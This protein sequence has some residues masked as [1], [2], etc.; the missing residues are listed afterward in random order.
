[1]KN[2]GVSMSDG[3]CVQWKRALV[4][5]V[6]L[7]GLVAV[8]GAAHAQFTVLSQSRTLKV[9]TFGSGSE[10]DWASDRLG[11]PGRYITTEWNKSDNSAWLDVG[12]FSSVLGVD[13]S[14]SSNSGS[15]RADLTSMVSDS[16]ISASGSFSAEANA[17][18]PTSGGVR[19]TASSSSLISLKVSFSLIE[20]TDLSFVFISDNGSGCNA[21]NYNYCNGGGGA[22][23]KLTGPG[24]DLVFYSGMAS[25]RQVLSLAPGTYDLNFT[26]SANGYTT[27]MTPYGRGSGTFGMSLMAVPEPSTTALM[28][29]GLLGV[30][31]FA[32]R[33]SHLTVLHTRD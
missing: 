24:T 27:V 10:Y 15:A 4:G 20:Q 12:A 1:M 32:T 2:L 6:G 22:S 19:G 16:V 18:Y 31:L 5:L 7:V 21:S 13:G 9:S 26:A 17:G 25:S 11:Q 33:R 14:V 23:G 28:F 30:V 8:H 3:I 29:L